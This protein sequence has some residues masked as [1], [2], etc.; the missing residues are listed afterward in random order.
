MSYGFGAPDGQRIVDHRR[1]DNAA[2]YPQLHSPNSNEGIFYLAGMK[3]KHRVG[4]RGGGSPLK[5]V[6]KPGLC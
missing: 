4:C 2:R 6:K 1:L 3:E 5:S